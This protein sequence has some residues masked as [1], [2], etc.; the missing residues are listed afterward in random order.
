[1]VQKLTKESGRNVGITRASGFDYQG[2]LEDNEEHLRHT[3][4]ILHEDVNFAES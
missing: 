2:I 1:M 4:R 3:H